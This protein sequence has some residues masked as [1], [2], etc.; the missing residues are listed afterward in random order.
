M[1]NFCGFNR[2]EEDNEDK[3]EFITKGNMFHKDGKYYI[4]YDQIDDNEVISTT[5]KIENEKVTIL[6]YGS[7]NTQMIV[8]KGK[9]HLSYYETPQGA[10]TIG[11]YSDKVDVNIG[12][13]TGE[14]KLYYDVEFDNV[15]A[16]RNAIEIK[17]KQV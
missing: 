5:V 7:M 10:V 1:I 4:K 6:R 15:L 12:E 13:E 9:K 16:S 17:Y 8:E 3:I 11:V 14:I 2:Y